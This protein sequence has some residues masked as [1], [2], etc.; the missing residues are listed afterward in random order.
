MFAGFE[1]NCRVMGFSGVSSVIDRPV[2]SDTEA[3]FVD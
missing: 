1:V 3:G 2:L